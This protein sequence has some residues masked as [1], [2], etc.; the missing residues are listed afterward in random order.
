MIGQ[1]LNKDVELVDE[2]SDV[3]TAFR[4]GLRERH[5]QREAMS[6]RMDPGKRTRGRRE[7]ECKLLE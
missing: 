7:R 1:A 6:S 2:L 3:S 4:V 5:R